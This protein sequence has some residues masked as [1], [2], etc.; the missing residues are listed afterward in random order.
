MPAC[1]RHNAF[2]IRQH[3]SVDRGERGPRYEDRS[4]PALCARCG[5]RFWSWDLSQC[6]GCDACRPRPHVPS[7]SSPK[8]GRTPEDDEE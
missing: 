8:D 4:G 5:V 3:P 2:E 7:N 1:L 6:F